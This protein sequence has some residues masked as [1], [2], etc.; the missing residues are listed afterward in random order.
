MH[1]ILSTRGPERWLSG[2]FR[3]RNDAETRW[4]SLPERDGTHHAIQAVS[5]TEFPFFIVEDGFGFTFLDPV[6]A[7]RV[8][9]TMSVPAENAEPILFAIVSE[10]QPD[11][12]GRDEM[13]SIR[14]VHL[15]GAH[16]AE[17]RKSG[18]LALTS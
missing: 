12:P 6:E 9:D 16:L 18:P 3:E 8:I 4:A 13:G 1:V 15:D 17:L 2:I 5:P 14:H 7:M 10:Y 11:L